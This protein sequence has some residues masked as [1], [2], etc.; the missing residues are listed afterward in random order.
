MEKENTARFYTE[1]QCRLAKENIET[2]TPTEDRL[3]VMLDGREVGVVVPNGGMRYREG[4]LDTDA[5]HDLYYRAAAIADEVHGYMELLDAAPLLKAQGLD[6]PYKLLAEYNGYV[7]GGMES[8]HGAQFTT[9]MRDYNREGVTLGHYFGE[10]FTAAKRDFAIR[11]GL[12]PKSE[13]FTPDELTVLYRG[14]ERLYEGSDETLTYE[15]ER[16]LE[17]LCEKL[18][19]LV[20]D[21]SQRQEQADGAQSVQQTM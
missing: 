17:R 1:L 19:S 15:S 11:A 13:I 4:A 12:I 18:E 21:M 14:V 10:D 5:A 8:T 7:L 6:M 20:P 9:W 3:T 16:E 2:R